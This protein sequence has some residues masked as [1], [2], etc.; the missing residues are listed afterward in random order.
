MLWFQSRLAMRSLQWGR[1]RVSA[2]MP[3]MSLVL[4][5]AIRLGFNG[6]ALV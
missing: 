6:A 4:P 5:Q 3:S 1:A 2:E